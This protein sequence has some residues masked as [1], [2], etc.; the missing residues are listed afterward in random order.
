MRRPLTTLLLLL[1]MAVIFGNKKVE[2]Y[3]S[4][5]FKASA[6]II[7]AGVISLEPPQ[8]TTP[9]ASLSSTET[10]ASSIYGELPISY[11]DI[12]IKASKLSKSWTF[13]GFGFQNDLDHIKIKLKDPGLKNHVISG[14]KKLMYSFVPLFLPKFEAEKT[15]Q[16]LSFTIYGFAE[17]HPIAFCSIGTEI[18][19]EGKKVNLG[20]LKREKKKSSQ[21]A[22]G[23]SRTSSENKPHNITVTVK[24]PYPKILNLFRKEEIIITLDGDLFSEEKHIESFSSTT[25]V[26]ISFENVPPGNYTL[27][28]KWGNEKIKKYISV[29]EDLHVDFSINF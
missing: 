7:I 12:K 9:K 21:K 18:K 20:A 19:G 5:V 29:Y 4:E 10:F 28:L 2:V 3:E 27:T 23:K 13:L 17:F 8:F 16:S 26:N 24:A 22:Q 15:H 14:N 1:L 25:L 11:L 6:P